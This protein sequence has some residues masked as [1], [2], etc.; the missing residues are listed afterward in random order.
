MD[1]Y[2]YMKI[3]HKYDLF[4]FAMFGSMVCLLVIQSLIS[5]HGNQLDVC[6]YNELSGNCTQQQG[7][8]VSFQRSSLCASI[9]L[10]PLEISMRISKSTTQPNII[11]SHHCKPFLALKDNQLTLCILWQQKFPFRSPSWILGSFHY[12]RFSH[13]P[14]KKCPPIPAVFPPTYSFHIPN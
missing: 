2:I 3:F 8:T 9:S 10:G 13:H 1:I 7:S 12:T 5:S 4:I 6:T 14:K 11:Q